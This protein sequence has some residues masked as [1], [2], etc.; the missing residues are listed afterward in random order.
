MR[1]YLVCELN[2][3][4]TCFFFVG[5][6]FGGTLAHLCTTHLWS[7]SQGICPELLEKNLLCITFGQPIISLPQ[8][9]NFMDRIADSSRFHAIYITGDIIPRMI[10]YLDPVYTE[11][12]KCDMPEKF[13]KQND[14]D[15][16]NSRTGVH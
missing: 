11:F 1:T 9:A 12:A 3:Y 8:T 2:L 4:E 7:L 16:V 14:P 15:K 10:R 5:F 13:R 6:S